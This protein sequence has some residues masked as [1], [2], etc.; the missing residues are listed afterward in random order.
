MAETET[1]TQTLLSDLRRNGKFE[2]DMHANVRDWGNVVDISVCAWRDDERW[3]G[4][5]VVM[6]RLDIGDDV[7]TG[8]DTMRLSV[9]VAQQLMDALWRAGLRPIEANGSAGQLGA[10]ERHLED[11]RALVSHKLGAPL[12]AAARK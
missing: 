9:K 6:Q 2:L 3:I 10:T 12:P 4:A 1:A 8:P 7:Y 11:M 5:P